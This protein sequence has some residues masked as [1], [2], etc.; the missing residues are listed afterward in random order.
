MRVLIIGGTGTISHFVLGYLVEAGHEVIILNHHEHA[1]PEGVKV[2]LCDRK[3]YP[4]F[5]RTVRE[6]GPYD[7]IYDM[8]TFSK[9]DGENAIEAY[10]NIAGQ[11]IFCSTVDVYSK[12]GTHYPV[13]EESERCPR[14]SFWYGYNKNLCEELFMEADRRG[15]FHTTILRPGHTYAEGENG[16]TLLF[17]LLGAGVGASY[18]LDRLLKGKP[19]ILHG[20]GMSVWNVT[21]GRDTGYAFF[22]AMCNPKTYGEAYTICGDECLCFREYYRTAARVLGAPE[23]QFVY[24]P[25]DVLVRM[26]PDRSAWAAENFTFN[27]ILDNSKAKR[28]LDFHQTVSWEEG[29]KLFWDYHLKKGDLENSDDP[30]FAFY[31][32]VIQKWNEMLA[33]I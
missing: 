18:L 1:V 14:E 11:V 27:N 7:C 12:T 13:T 19:I 15:Y 23:P 6:N 28:D 25:S 9:E 31:D 8:I 5:I 10:K 2:L 17:S 16:T 30:A 21:H 4:E 29:V 3:N 32:E 22:R 33:L 20:D 24:I 26:V